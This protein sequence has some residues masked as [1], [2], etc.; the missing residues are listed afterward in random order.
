[1]FF[2]FRAHIHDAVELYQQNRKSSS[3]SDYEVSSVIMSSSDKIPSTTR[4]K[5]DIK[6][7]TVALQENPCYVATKEFS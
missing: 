7:D 5:Q 6:A 4:S 1:M 2:I 3:A